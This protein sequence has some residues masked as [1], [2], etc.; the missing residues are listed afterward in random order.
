MKL[1]ENWYLFVA[2]FCVGAVVGAKAYAYYKLPTSDKVKLFKAAL[3][4][5]VKKAEEQFYGGGRG[6]EKLGYVW[7]EIKERFPFI[8]LFM[9]KETFKTLVNGALIEV[10]IWLKKE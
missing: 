8:T 2:L 6:A 7:D 1:L 10:G 9:D 5:L 3:H 4:E